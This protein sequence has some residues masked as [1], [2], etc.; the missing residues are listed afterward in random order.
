[1]DALYKLKLTPAEVTKHTFDVIVARPI[2]VWDTIN[3]V[4]WQPGRAINDI[5]AK[6]FL[7]DLAIAHGQ[8]DTRNVIIW[9]ALQSRECFENIIANPQ[10]ALHY[11]E[12]A[13]TE[14][15]GDMFSAL[16]QE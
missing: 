14:L 13:E 15:N 10:L 11:V 2:D 16:R 9:A 1:M 5:S 12:Q 4:R 3:A 8:D 7:Y 6:K